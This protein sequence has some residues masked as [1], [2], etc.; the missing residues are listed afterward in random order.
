MNELGQAGDSQ[1]KMMLS[2]VSEVPLSPTID[3]GTDKIK[4][5]DSYHNTNYCS[6]FLV[7]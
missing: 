4:T 7:E 2:G 6:Y 5:N 3:P 1:Y